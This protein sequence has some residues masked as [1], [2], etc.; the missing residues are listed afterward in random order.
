MRWLK[1][2]NA[3]AEGNQ[4]QCGCSH[5]DGCTYVNVG[6]DADGGVAPMSDDGRHT[7]DLG[8]N[9]SRTNTECRLRIM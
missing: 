7:G 8:G 3:V 5:R 1:E 9:V 4:R 6:K 2:T